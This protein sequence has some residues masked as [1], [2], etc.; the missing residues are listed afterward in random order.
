M[1]K[2]LDKLQTEKKVEAT[3]PKR[4]EVIEV[5]EAPVSEAK[6]EPSGSNSKFSKCISRYLNLLRKV[7]FSQ[8]KKGL[9]VMVLI[10]ISFNVG[11]YFESRTRNTVYILDEKKFLTLA[12]VGIATGDK[13]S[14]VEISDSDKEK[15]VV[16]VNEL[17]RVLH[18]EYVKHP[19]LIK[20]QGSYQIYS[21]VNKID[22]TE[23]VIKK[24]I[25]EKRWKEI[26]KTLAK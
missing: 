23:P 5:T 25:G 4:S 6:E 18:E 9:L 14:G 12:S 17:N 3:E 19:V 15:V 13:A 26:G 7:S 21:A 8:C 20:K 10:G 2:D 22:L 24:V 1:T 16:A 11:Q